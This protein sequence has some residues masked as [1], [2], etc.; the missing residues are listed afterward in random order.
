MHKPPNRDKKRLPVSGQGRRFGRSKTFI[1]KDLLSRTGI[2]GKQITQVVD[3]QEF[4]LKLLRERLGEELGGQVTG[5]I[6][7]A[8][9]LT[10]FAATPAW[11]ARLKFRIA[12]LW[13]EL[14]ATRAGL[15][16]LVIKVQPAADRAGART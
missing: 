9:T 13:P 4:W 7:K 10:V 16:R 12:E 5:A 3:Q 1:V 11:S 2:F 14:Q 6:E 15:S 8:G